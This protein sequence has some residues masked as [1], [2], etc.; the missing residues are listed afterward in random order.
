MGSSRNVKVTSTPTWSCPAY[1]IG[2]SHNTSLFKKAIKS[3]ADIDAKSRSTCPVAISL[4]GKTSKSKK[5]RRKERK[6]KKRKKKEK[7]KKKRKEGKKKEKEE[8]E[9][10]KRKKRKVKKKEKKEKKRRG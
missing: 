6:A 5:D 7:K 8:K 10:K 2:S 3:G 9:K 4:K 1:V